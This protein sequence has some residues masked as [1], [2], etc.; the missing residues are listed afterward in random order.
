MT[1]E[2]SMVSIDDDE[3]QAAKLMRARH[4]RR[5]PI[6]DG[7]RVAGIVTLDDLIMTGAIEIRLMAEIVAAQLSEPSAAKLAGVTHPTGADGA[8]ASREDPIA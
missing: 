2:P 6:L 7:E 8:R 3:L 4:V 5:L 1:P